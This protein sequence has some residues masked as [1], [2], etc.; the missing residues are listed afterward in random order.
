MRV[1]GLCQAYNEDMFMH[2]CLQWAVGCVDK[3]IITEGSLTPFGNQPK[4]SQDRT[5]QTIERFKQAYDRDDKME[6]YDA[7]DPEQ[8]PKNR[9]DFE[10]LNKNFMLE[11]AAPEPG[12]L[13]F[14]L[15]VDEFWHEENFQAVVERFRKDDKLVHVPVEEYQ[16]AYNLRTCFNAEHNGRFMRYVSGARFGATNHFVHPGVGDIT[17][18]YSNLLPR[19]V[20]QMCHLCWCK[21]PL[22]IR[23]KVLSFARPSFTLWYNLVY[24]G[25]PVH[26]EEVYK[27]NERIPPWR[28]TGFAEGQHKKL[29][30]FEGELPW[31]IKNMTWDHADYIRRRHD[32]LVIT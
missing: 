27:L 8:V 29:K 9:E 20:T 15:D 16:F 10:G 22:G 18:D 19:E 25:Y 17:K 5:R 4:R 12:D 14:I 24:L 7:V 2:Q 11:K 26:G 28:G 21:H 30:K 6:I 32:E 1:I 23:Q 13:I 31:P 3:L